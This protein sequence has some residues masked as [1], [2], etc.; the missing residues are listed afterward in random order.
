MVNAL[1]RKAQVLS[2]CFLII[3]KGVTALDTS[4]YSNATDSS[5]NQPCKRMKSNTSKGNITNTPKVIS[6][7]KVKKG[8]KKCHEEAKSKIGSY[9]TISSSS[10]LY[11]SCKTIDINN[12][13]VI[14]LGAKYVQKALNQGLIGLCTGEKRRITSPSQYAYGNNFHRGNYGN[15]IVPPNSTLVWNVEIIDIQVAPPQGFLNQIF[16][17]A[18]MALPVGHPAE[19]YE[20]LRENVNLAKELAQQDHT[21]AKE[22]MNAMKELEN[23]LNDFLSNKSIGNI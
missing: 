11:K 20:R 16:H 14:Q 9:V 3:I 4:L 6:L 13:Q 10:F 15:S 12:I 2:I 22:N 18:K 17:G 21:W 19:A 5:I 23:T 7:G 8:S 1:H